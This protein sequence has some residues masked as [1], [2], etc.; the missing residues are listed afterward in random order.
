MSLEEYTEVTE[1]SGVPGGREEVGD[2]KRGDID[3]R[4]GRKPRRSGIR[5]LLLP[6][7]I[8]PVLSS[9]CLRA[10]VA[11]YILCAL[12]LISVLSVSD[13]TSLGLFSVPRCLCG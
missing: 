6:L 10:S 1:G 4:T 8:P 11:Q 5:D 3:S 12:F 13:F 2:V 7:K 9:P